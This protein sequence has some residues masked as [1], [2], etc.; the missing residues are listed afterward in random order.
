VKPAIDGKKS[1]SMLPSRPLNTYHLRGPAL[2]RSDIMSTG[3]RRY[4]TRCDDT[5]AVES[6]FEHAR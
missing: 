6:G 5:P 4:V 2:A 3:R 1:F